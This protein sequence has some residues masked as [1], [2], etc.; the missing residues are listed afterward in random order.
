M[1][2]RGSA[3]AQGH[4]QSS[5]PCSTIN[6]HRLHGRAHRRIH[7]SS[8]LAS[9]RVVSELQPLRCDHIDCEKPCTTNVPVALNPCHNAFFVGLGFHHIDKAGHNQ[10]LAVLFDQHYSALSERR[11]VFWW[12]MFRFIN[13][14]AAACHAWAPTLLKSGDDEPLLRNTR[15]RSCARKTSDQSLAS[16]G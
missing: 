8:F 6:A 7:A 9:A 1:A 13:R 12:R 3:H 10:S 5:L 15:G 4:H 16:S 14:S 11:R 2:K